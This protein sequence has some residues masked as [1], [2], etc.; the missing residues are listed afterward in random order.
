MLCATCDGLLTP[1]RLFC[2]HCGAVTPEGE[3]VM[4]PERTA[5]AP[6]ALPGSAS[7]ARPIRRTPERTSGSAVASLAFGILSY[8]A[9]PIVGA[10]AAVVFG[11]Y[12]RREIRISGHR[13]EGMPLAT[14]GLVL[15]YAQLALVGLALAFAFAVA[16]AAVAAGA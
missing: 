4:N 7:P 16:L 11:H 15:G 2:V 3:R 5:P 12:A 1:G 6:A 14:T 9:L 8:V 13:I 10:L